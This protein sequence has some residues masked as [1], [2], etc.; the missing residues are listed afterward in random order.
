M[1]WTQPINIYCER[2]DA[3]FWSEP[4]NAITNAAFVAAAIW[5]AIEARRR[6]EPNPLVWLLIA[7][8]AV[9][10]IGSFLFHTFANRWS[11]FADV[12]PIWTFVA[13]YVLVAINRIGHVRPGRILIGLAA[14]I[15]A[16][17]IYAAMGEGSGGTTAAP[18]QPDP[19][20]GSLQYLP[21]VIA[22]LV[23]V[24]VMQIRRHP[25]RNWALAG[26]G[27]FA[28]S[29]VFRTIDPQ[30]CDGFPLGTHFLWHLLNGLMIGIVLQILL[31]SPRPA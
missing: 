11:A 23:F 6:A 19:F 30:V 29:L 5:G 1:N 31:R 16:I 18:P 3:G 2:L 21:A 4:V 20:N 14:V 27:V 7:L 24:I 26:F 15:G 17:T 10:G 22:F 12:L 9:I 25:M 28:L 8:A 13:L